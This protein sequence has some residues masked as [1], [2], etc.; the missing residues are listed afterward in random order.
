[1]IAHVRRL[2]LAMLAL[3]FAVGGLQAQTVD[4]AREAAAKDLMNAMN[5][6][7]QFQKS[8]TAM[9]DLLTKQMASQPG[10]DKMKVVMD[11]IFDPQSEGVKVYFV[12]A[13]AAYIAFFAERFT[14]EE[15]KEIAVFQSSPVGRKMQDAM[16]DMIGALG[17]PLAK[18]QE[19]IKKQIVEELQAKP[20]E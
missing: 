11:K 13:E 6:Q 14:V 4:P 20:K 19:S 9:K 7:E 10:G 17:P 18:F 1:M 5:V 16:P 15:M 3:L 12:D 2:L 8:T